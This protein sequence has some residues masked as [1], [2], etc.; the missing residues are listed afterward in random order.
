MNNYKEAT[1][2]FYTLIH[3]RLNETNQWETNKYKLHVGDDAAF[4][5]IVYHRHQPNGV[6]PEVQIFVEIRD[7]NLKEV[8]KRCVLHVDQ[9]T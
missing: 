8:L 5:F 4:E 3:Q 9:S 6:K 7:A 2:D 1:T